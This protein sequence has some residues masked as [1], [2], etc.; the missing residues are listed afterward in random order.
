MNKKH[1]GYAILYAALLGL[2]CALALTG[3]DR[4]TAERK[5]ANEQAEEVRN[6]LGVLGVPFEAGAS[7]AELLSVY[8]SNVRDEE[9]N[10]RGFF[11]F[12]H[13]SEGELLATR[14]EGPGLWGPVEGFLCLRGD[15]ETI[16]AVSFY[17]QEETPGLGGEISSDAFQDQFRG[18][19]ITTA[20]GVGIRVVADGADAPNEVDAIAG[21][22]M[23]SDKVQ[24]MLNETIEEIVGAD[25]RPARRDSHGG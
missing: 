7:A 20:A 17:R 25:V 21:A 6:I 11:V 3:V 14:F 9:R 4:F 5:A 16:Y 1:S 12:D 19:K 13:P 2:V 8:E 10:G 24:A 23:T 18:K 22:T 15:R